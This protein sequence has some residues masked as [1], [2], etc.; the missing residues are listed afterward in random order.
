MGR[1]IS[2]HWEW[3]FASAKQSSNFGE[4][5]EY[6]IDKSGVNSFV[7]RYLSDYGEIVKLYIG[8]RKEFMDMLREYVKD[9]KRNDAKYNSNEHHKDENEY[10]TKYMM[11]EF[12]EYVKNVDRPDWE[13][14]VEY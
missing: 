2:G 11:L 13:F 9:W 4:V 5:L 1:W 3:K 6:L 8:N 14:H 12:M 7:T 10:W